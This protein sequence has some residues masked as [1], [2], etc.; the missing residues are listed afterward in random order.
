VG[1]NRMYVLEVEDRGRSWISGIFRSKDSLNQYFTLIPE[2]LKDLQHSKELPM[3]DY[4]FYIV[5]KQ[6]YKYLNQTEFLNYLDNYD[7][8]SK[9]EEVFFNIYMI[10]T[11]YK[12]DKPGT[13][14][15]GILKHDHVTSDFMEFYKNE[16]ETFLRRRRF[17]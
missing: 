9:D 10:D 5:E 12:P 8:D 13:D 16:R 15:M 1:E 4:P 3:T 14:N 2:H 17:L 11:D 6:G 7:Y